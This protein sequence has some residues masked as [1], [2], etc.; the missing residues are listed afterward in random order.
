MPCT[1]IY[2][3]R[4]AESYANIE[5][6]F[7]ARPPGPGL[8]PRGRQQ[9]EA[10]CRR[11]IA[12]GVRPALI[13]SSPMRRALETASPLCEASGLVAEV[14]PDLTE[15][16]LGVWEGLTAN[17]LQASKQY[18]TWLADPETFPPPGGERLSQM[19]SRVARVL[20]EVAPRSVGH[21]IAAFSHMHPIVALVLSA[22]GRPFGEH[23]RVGVPNCGIV[24][25]RW[26]GAA[27]R[28]VDIDPGLPLLE[29][30]NA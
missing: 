7:C 22:Q 15:T 11:L 21:A 13:L 25:V 16:G 30:P 27:L 23:R 3:V 20:H 12:S 1:D 19:A 17:D 24:H 2:L 18:R 26:D 29:P 14:H 10:A 28:V 5:G 4:H 9:A 6:R 8:T